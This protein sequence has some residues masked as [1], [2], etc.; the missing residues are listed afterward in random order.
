[1]TSKTGHRKGCPE[2]SFEPMH[3]ACWVEEDGTV[4]RYPQPT[5]DELQTEVERLQTAL[6]AIVAT[7]RQPGPG[8]GYYVM[9]DVMAIAVEALGNDKCR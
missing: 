6:E 1:M 3:H 5:Y 2:S 9:P 7:P 4:T 8:A